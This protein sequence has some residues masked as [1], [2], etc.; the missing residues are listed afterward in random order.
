MKNRQYFQAVVEVVVMVVYS[1]EASFFHSKVGQLSTRFVLTICSQC[2]C[3]Q[4]GIEFVLRNTQAKHTNI[5]PH[6]WPSSPGHYSSSTLI[7]HSFISPT[8]KPERE[9]HDQTLGVLMESVATFAVEVGNISCCKI[10]AQNK[11]QTT[12]RQTLWELAVSR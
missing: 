11:P 12:G 1:S 3:F 5:S 7:C 6:R 8:A 10:L 9:K 2:F 4:S